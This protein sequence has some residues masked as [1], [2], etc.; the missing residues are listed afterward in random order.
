MKRTKQWLQKNRH[1]SPNWIEYQK[2]S[3]SKVNR[4]C[5]YAVKL[6]N[7]I[8][9]TSEPPTDQIQ[10]AK[11]LLINPVSKINKV[12]RDAVIAKRGVTTF[13]EVRIGSDSPE[14]CDRIVYLTHYN[15]V[16]IRDLIDTSMPDYKVEDIKLAKSEMGE[17]LMYYALTKA[18]TADLEDVHLHT[19]CIQDPTV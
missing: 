4:R 5:T 16:S 18:D 2:T 11:K 3:P 12:K 8:P 10:M 19:N 15:V 17:A 6:N 9:Y 14:D 1:D 7:H 13:Q